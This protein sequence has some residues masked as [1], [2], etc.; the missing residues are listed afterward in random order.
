MKGMREEYPEPQRKRKV[1]LSLNGEWQFRFGDGEEKGGNKYPL[2]IQVP[3][4][5]QSKASGLGDETQHDVLWYKREFSLTEELKQ[6]KTVRLNFLAVDRDCQVYVNGKF[7]LAHE[8]GYGGFSA[9]IKPYLVDGVQSI[10][11]RVYDLMTKVYPRGKQ[12][13]EE[14]RQRCWYACTSGIW[15][16]VWL[17]GANGDYVK[18]LQFISDPERTTA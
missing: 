18:E 15:Q 7:V 13:W 4:A 14:G 11:I 5:Y 17:D 1:W 2:K 16:S 10:E 8:G 9:D 12:N 3:F 6:C